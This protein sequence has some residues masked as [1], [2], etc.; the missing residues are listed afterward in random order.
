MLN[1]NKMD[2]MSHDVII[3]GGGPSGLNAAR[4]LAQEGLSVGVLEKKKEIGN[5]IICT[6]IV[7]QK[8]FQEFD[9]LKDS[10]R[11]EINKVKMMS[12]FSSC[13]TYEHPFPFAY[14]VDRERFDRYLGRSAQS[15]GAEIRLENEVVDI[16]TNQDF[17]EVAAVER[18][19]K[20]VRYRAHV[21]VI[22]TGIN[23][24]L[25]KK[26]GLGC[27][28]QFLNGVQAE[29]DI[30]G[31]ECTHVFLGRDVAAGAF[32]WLVPIKNE[33][34]RIGLM[35]D[36]NPEEQFLRLIKKLYP[37][38]VLDLDKSRIQFK[39]IAQGLVSGTY[40]DRVLAVGE[41]AGQ[42]KTTTGGG[43][44]FGLLCSEIATRVLMK[45][46]KKGSFSTPLLAEY[47]KLWKKA[48]QKEIQI[49]YYARKIC[50]KMSD[51]Q[52]E[53]MFQIALSDGVIPLIREKGNFDLHSELILI[54]LR[55]MPFRQFMKEK[56]GNAGSVKE[57]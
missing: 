11:T 30:N 15:Q 32:A 23:Y 4:F 12:P 56:I 35:T 25:H 5:H 24:R 40:G 8:A 19:E 41:A 53:K 21:A 33:S 39:A 37:E 22:A 50:S 6:G 57:T 44:Y 14:A 47:E 18:G 29:L 1:G 26:L 55:R 38:K 34:I 10:I 2:R 49:G 27:P 54:L 7:G 31:V 48:I 42:V 13:L 16:S 20:Q 3:V 43:I 36:K 52:I 46:F 45:G 9:L 51:K 17:V 28:R